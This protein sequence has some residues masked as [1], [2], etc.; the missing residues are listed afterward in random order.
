M[1]TIGK[2]VSR[3]RNTIK[4]VKQDP[5]ITDRYLY[6]LILKYGRAYIKQQDTIKKLLRLGSL[7]KT[8]PCMDLI[9]VNKVEACCGDV[10]SDCLIKRTKD[11][12][13]NIMEADFGPIFRTVS[14]IDGSIEVFPTTPSTYTSMT[15]MSSWKYNK[16]K[17]Y[18]FL[19]QYIYIPDIQWEEIKLDGIF[20]GDLGPFQCGENGEDKAC[21][22]R[23]DQQIAIPDFLFAEIEKQVMADLAYLLNIPPDLLPAD[24][25]HILR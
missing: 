11:K 9:Q 23:Q 3:V 19:N 8:I 20:E 4:A 25:Q 21:E 1:E 18:W 10:S 2:V 17:Y 6:S 12:V 7:F 14:S 13:P 22:L 16:R 5:F 24:K 15:K